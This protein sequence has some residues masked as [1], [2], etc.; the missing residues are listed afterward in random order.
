[1]KR[2]RLFLFLIYCL[3]QLSH[4]DAQVS[5]TFKVTTGR[6]IEYEVLLLTRTAGG[7]TLRTPIS[8]SDFDRGFNQLMWELINTGEGTSVKA[9]RVGNTIR[10]QGRFRGRKVSRKY[11][12]DARPWYQYPEVTLQE[13]VLSANQ[14]TQFW[15]ISPDDLTIFE[16]EA[17]KMGRETVEVAGHSVKAIRIR[18]KAL[19]FAGNFWHADYWFSWADGSYL[20]YQAVHG[21]P[22]TPPT[23]KELVESAR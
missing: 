9:Q 4:I 5:Y 14:R 13:F 2:I 20:R 3:M 11:A 10:L 23:V 7:F 15:I 22:G 12:I 16:F 8:R 18:I 1:M 6:K 19:G 21:G 17:V